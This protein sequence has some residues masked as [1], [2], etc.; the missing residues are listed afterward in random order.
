M[1]GTQ[2]PNIP[3]QFIHM[4]RHFSHSTPESHWSSLLF[5]WPCFPLPVYSHWPTYT[6]ITHHSGHCYGNSLASRVN[7]IKAPCMSSWFGPCLT[8]VLSPTT[9]G[10]L[11]ASP[12][13]MNHWK[14]LILVQGPCPLHFLIASAPQPARVF[15]PLFIHQLSDGI[16]RVFLSSAPN[17]C[18]HPT[19]SATQS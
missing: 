10:L 4:R 2:F 9:P 8:P 16:Q 11:F 19:P 17:F 5:L 3:N 1:K 12:V 14:S 13:M 18:A 6:L 7:P 15:P